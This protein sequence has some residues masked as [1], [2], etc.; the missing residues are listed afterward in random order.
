MHTESMFQTTNKI[1]DLLKK[2]NHHHQGMKQA[3]KRVITV[4]ITEQD[5]LNL[6]WVMDQNKAQCC[7]QSRNFTSVIMKTTKKQRAQQNSS[8][9]IWV[10]SS[11]QNLS[12]QDSNPQCRKTK[13]QVILM[14]LRVSPTPQIS[15]PKSTH[16]H[17]CM[18]AL[19]PPHQ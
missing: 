3:W 4:E 14:L 15:S 6:F 9:R 13:P 10:Q 2:Y 1:T 16:T 5:N 19:S 17:T 11:A 18:L 12:A 7:F 8:Y